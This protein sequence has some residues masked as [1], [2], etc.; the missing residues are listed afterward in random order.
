MGKVSFF[1]ADYRDGRV[2][3]GDKTYPAGTFA[4]HL[5]NQ[6][7]LNDTAARISVYAGGSRFLE[8]RLRLGYIKPREFAEVGEKIAHIFDTLPSLKPFDMLDVESERKKVELIFTEENGERI[9]EYFR[10]KAKVMDMDAGQ[11]ALDILPPEYEEVFFKDA[12][13]F[14]QEVFSIIRFYDA[15]GEDMRIAFG[16]LQ[17]FVRRVDEAERFD[18]AHLLP[19]ALEIFHA[20]PLPTKTEY[21]SVKKTS[22][23]AAGT[24][25]RRLYFENY[26]SFIITDFFEGLHYG[27][28]PRRCEICGKYFL[29]TSAVRQKY[30]TGYAPEKVKGKSVSCRKYAARLNRKELAEGNPVIRIYKNR[31]SAIRVER[32]RGKILPEFASAALA[33]A[34]EHM[35]V[36]KNDVEYANGQ[37]EADMSRDKLYAD[38]EKSMN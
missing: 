8:N 13:R 24:L 3:I 26:Y 20:P 32:Q 27:H 1:S 7:Y 4:V 22:R 12:E 25:A 15:L 36:A 17:Q 35:Q 38:T 16:R 29:M 5:L 11:I 37:Y 9:D 34:K 28:Y 18:E 19:I 30:C 10:S 14:L 2:S 21:I 6:Y 31:C 33:L 23:S